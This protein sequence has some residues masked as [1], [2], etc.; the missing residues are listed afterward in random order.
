MANT[1]ANQ[2]ATGTQHEQNWKDQA[3]E[4]ANRGAE[5]VREG[6]SSAA[7]TLGEHPMTSVL[8]GFGLGLGVG[9]LL[10]TALA[11]P[12][13]RRQWYEFDTSQAEKVGQRVLDAIAGVL[14]DNVSK[15]LHR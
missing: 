15:R 14:P 10:G 12:P 2:G 1:Q 7:A 5:Y 9:L 3:G 11:E 4:Y 13:R 8:M 6:Y